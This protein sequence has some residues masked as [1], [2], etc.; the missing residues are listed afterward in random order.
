MTQLTDD[1]FAVEV[2]EGA[3]NYRIMKFSQPETL[4]YD[5]SIQKGDRCTTGLIAMIDL[6]PGNWRVLCTTREVKAMHAPALFGYAMLSD[7][8]AQETI[9]A[10]I[11]SKGLD[12]DKNHCLIE[13]L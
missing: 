5:Y 2:P 12:A 3:A 4:S 13:K 11:T 8:Y 7:H 10:L 1:L 9:K 6:P